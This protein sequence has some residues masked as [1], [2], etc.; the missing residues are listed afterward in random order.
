M[1][2]TITPAMPRAKFPRLMESDSVVL[3]VADQDRDSLT[4][5]IVFAKKDCIYSVGDYSKGW[6]TPNFSDFNGTINL[7]ND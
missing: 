1:K 2:S 6:Y 7:G 3:L 4:G 5:T